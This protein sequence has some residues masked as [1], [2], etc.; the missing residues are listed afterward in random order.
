[1][2][3]QIEGKNKSELSSRKKRP[4]PQFDI[5]KLTI[6][7]LGQLEKIHKKLFKEKKEENDEKLENGPKRIQLLQKEQEEEADGKSAANG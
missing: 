7:E 1:M 6:G 4:R 2:T 3:Q 5:E